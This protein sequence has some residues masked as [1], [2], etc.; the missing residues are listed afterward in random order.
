MMVCIGEG[1]IA[2]GADADDDDDDD[3]TIVMVGMMEVSLSTVV[4]C[5][6]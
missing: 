5:P 4:S 1:S 6:V 2:D 3:D